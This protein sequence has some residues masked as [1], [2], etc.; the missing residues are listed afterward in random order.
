MATAQD[1]GPKSAQGIPLVSYRA[2]A[3]QDDIPTQ[4]VASLKRKG[5]DDELTRML[6]EREANQLGNDAPSWALAMNAGIMQR[7]NV[8]ERSHEDMGTR[9]SML[10][11][12]S[13]EDGTRIKGLEEQVCAMQKKLEALLTGERSLPAPVQE[14]PPNDPWAGYK[15]V[16]PPQSL[17]SPSGFLRDTKDFN[18]LVLGGWNRDTK[19]Q[20]IESELDAF[21]Q[22]HSIPD[23]NR[24]VVYGKRASVAHCYLK[25][26]P[27][28]GAK[29]RFFT[30]LPQPNKKF[31]LSSGSLL[32][33]SPSK[34]LEVRMRNKVLGVA[35]QRLL[36]IF[37]MDINAGEVEIDWY[38][39]VVWIG[40]RRMLALNDKGLFS[41]PDERCVETRITVD[42]F[43]R[44]VHFNLAAMHSMISIPIPDLEA[45]VHSD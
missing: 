3:S 6:A 26:L 43:E 2:M 5:P 1:L 38:Q 13:A 35:I 42:G 41:R 29:E 23:L 33:I 10:E 45:A 15:R 31:K 27:E 28:Q 9:M 14:N 4:P 40:D 11:Q 44:T 39:G 22:Q 12:K 30:L 32:W 24:S 36:R 7:F 16:P 17:Q 37:R 21:L 25:N 8:L 20:L 34:P 19:R 18:H